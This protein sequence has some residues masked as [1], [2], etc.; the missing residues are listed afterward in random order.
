M[1]LNEY[2]T[3]GFHLRVCYFLQSASTTAA[4]DSSSQRSTIATPS[5][6]NAT[7]SERTTQPAPG[8]SPVPTASANANLTAASK[9]GSAP[10]RSPGRTAPAGT[11]STGTIGGA[12]N[13]AGAPSSAAT[14]LPQASDRAAAAGKDTVDA[15]ISLAPHG[16]SVSLT[17][18][19]G[20]A[21]ISTTST[22]TVLYV[23]AIP[24]KLLV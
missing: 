3:L 8:P 1:L 23:L 10:P 18:S 6:S 2:Q 7:A 15:R 19:S 17:V 22:R 20:S 16:S 13:V 21:C 9:S 4:P 24:Q 12:Q 5:S 14:A 11:S